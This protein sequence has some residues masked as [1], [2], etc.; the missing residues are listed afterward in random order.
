M[1]I[2]FWGATIVIVYTFLGYPVWLWLRS[3]WSPW[4]VQRGSYTPTVS[5]VMVV[6]NEAAV[7]E[8]KLQNL[9][10]LNYPQ[11][12]FEIVVMSDGSSDETNEI[13]SSYG[14]RENVRV[15]LGE[16]SQGKASGLNEA[17]SVARGEIVLFTDARQ[18]IE[19][20]ALRLLAQDFADSSVGCVS[21]Q[22]MLGDPI[23]GQANR[24]MGLY[25]RI[26]KKVREWESAS[27]SV[28]GATGAIYAVRWNLVM[29]V[30]PE[31]VLDDV[32]IPMQVVH[33]GA[34]VIF[35]PR[36]RAWDL[37]DLGKSREFNRKVRTLGGNYQLLQ[38]AP[39]LLSKENPIRFEF[40]S[41]K[42]SRLTAPFA[43]LVVLLTSCFLT[44]PIYRIALI[45]QVAFY[46][47][48]LLAMMQLAKGPLARMAD[49]AYTF[50]VLNTAAAVAFGNFVT[51]RKTIWVR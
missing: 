26:E 39:W 36:A 2:A 50:V 28:V 17:I 37:P 41:H 23:S 21:G 46:G 42:V 3:R 45:L 44:G 34:R 4:P 12:L 11:E 15:L 25:W 10:A 24:G 31:T 30:P 35:D 5:A 18:I 49:A 7:L 33:Q 47:L 51:G 16:H 6:R 27:G 48:S 1:K 9:L 32:Y 38:L 13:L 29:P 40:L 19:S 22:L 43:L 14:K 20:D 8:R